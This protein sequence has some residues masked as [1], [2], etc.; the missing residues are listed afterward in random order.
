MTTVAVPEA[1]PPAKVSLEQALRDIDVNYQQKNH[2]VEALTQLMVL[3][4]D[5][6]TSHKLWLHIGHIYTRMANWSD[7]MG[8][9]DTALALNPQLHEAQLLKSLA[10]FSL[11]RR[12]EACALVDKTV[13]RLPTSGAW[14]MRAYLYAHTSSDPQLALDTAH[15]WGR[16][17]AD[18]VTRKAKPLVVANRDPRKK[19]RVGYVT[20]DFRQH[21]VAFFMLPVLMHHNREDVEIHVYNNGPWDGLTPLLRLQVPVWHDVMGLSAEQTY[22]LIRNDEIDVL[23]DLSGYTHGNCLSVFALRAAPVQATWVG[24]IQPLGMKAM[25]YRLVAPGLVPPSQAPYYSEALFQLKASACYAPPT[26]S[27]LSEVP[28]M[29]RNGYPTLISPNSS[30]KITDEMLKV[31]ARILHER[32]DARLIIMVKELDANAAQADMQPRVEAAGFP[33]ERVSVL[34][35]QPLNQFMEIGHIAD[36]MLD[37]A[38]ISGGTTTLH[39]LWMGMP[40]VTLDAERGVDACSAYLLR[41]LGFEAEIA[42]SEEEYVQIALRLMADAERLYAQRHSIREHMRSSIF[43]NYATYTADVEKSFRIMW[44]NY[45]RGDQR[46]LRLDVDIEARI[47]AL[48]GRAS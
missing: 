38:P 22:Q 24:Y 23:I 18:P 37:T 28:P 36:I 2:F 8:A 34:H 16:R 6:V 1:N 21:S 32:T 11:G 12:Q 4:K 29:V 26:Y 43:M 10:L 39:S 35:Q 9:L 42:Q 20:G 40:V 48:E 5:H 47:A 46:D 30:A 14:M 3:A 15:D 7:A 44:L 25:D 27:P 13:R 31:W 45:L 17:F 33:L 41:E 19:L